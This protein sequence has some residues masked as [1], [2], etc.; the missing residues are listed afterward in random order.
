MPT[1]GRVERRFADVRSIVGVRPRR[2]T[3]SQRD[4]EDDGEDTQR[5]PVAHAYRFSSA[6]F[7]ATAQSDSS[8]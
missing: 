6:R 8:D 2:T 3:G 5:R 4:D 1:S 7:E